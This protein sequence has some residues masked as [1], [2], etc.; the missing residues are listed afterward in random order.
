MGRQSEP[1]NKSLMFWEY[2]SKSSFRVF[3]FNLQS[4]TPKSAYTILGDTYICIYIIK[5]HKQNKYNY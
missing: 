4:D 1:S 3:I 5:Q 2:M